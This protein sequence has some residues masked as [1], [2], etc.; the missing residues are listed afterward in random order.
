VPAFRRSLHPVGSALSSSN[1][2]G[3]VCIGDPPTV[4]SAIHHQH[5]SFRPKGGPE[6][7]RNTICILHLQTKEAIIAAQ[8]HDFCN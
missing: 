3:V 2:D 7:C 1:P 5:S 8:F 6:E 4:R